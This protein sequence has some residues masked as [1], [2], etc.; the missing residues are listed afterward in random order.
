MNNIV[1][2]LSGSTAALR[3]AEQYLAD[4]GYTISA[5]PSS[6]V[7]HLLLPVPSFDSGGTIKGGGLIEDTLKL[8]PENVTIFGGNLQNSALSAKNAL[9]CCKIPYTWPKTQP[10]PLTVL[11]ALPGT[12]FL[13][14][15]T[16][17]PYWSSAGAGSVNALPASSKPWV[18]M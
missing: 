10:S 6:A 16:N 18:P 12:T 15:L 7:T 2:H 8:F 1:F 11:S 14:Y 17:A 13:L 5:E 3:Y 4:R 9:I